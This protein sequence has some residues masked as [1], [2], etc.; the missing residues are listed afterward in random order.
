[1]TNQDFDTTDVDLWVGVPLGGGEL[2]DPVHPNDIRRWDSGD[3]E[4]EPVVLRRDLHR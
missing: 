3:A 2:K 4:P 1:M